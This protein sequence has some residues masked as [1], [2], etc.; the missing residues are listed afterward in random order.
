LNSSIIVFNNNRKSNRVFVEGAMVCCYAW[1]SAPVAGTD[2]SRAL[3]V[4]GR[5]FHFPINFTTRQHLTF[6]VTKS[7]I[8]SYVG[9]MLDLLE[10]CQQVY[11]LLIHEQRTYHRELWNSQIHHPRKYKICDRV[12]ACVQVQS[13]QSK[14]Q[15]QKL[16]YRT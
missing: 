5:K 11:K 8:Q 1:N 7:G 3:S 13:K 2:L 15:V 4:L 12:F 9:N 10:K 16:A 14:G 6:N